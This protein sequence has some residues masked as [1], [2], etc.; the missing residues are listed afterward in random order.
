MNAVKFTH[1]QAFQGTNFL[2][3]RVHVFELDKMP[4]F[5][6]APSCVT[7]REPFRGHSSCKN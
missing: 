6:K 7:E 1:K 2:Q 5:L 4:D 3:R